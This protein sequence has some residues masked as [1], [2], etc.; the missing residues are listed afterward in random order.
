MRRRPLPARVWD[1]LLGNALGNAAAPRRPRL[2]L[3]ALEAREVPAVITQWDFNSPTPD[4]DVTTGTDTPAVGAGPNATIT[5]V[6]GLAH[7]FYAAESPV[8]G[9]SSDPATADDSSYYLTS[10]PAQGTAPNSAGVEWHVDT[11]GYKDVVVT[12]DQYHSLT[13]PKHTRFRYSTDGGATWAD[14]PLFTAA[15][16]GD[17]WYNGR[18][19]DL[20]GV[21]AAGN[22]PDLRVKVVAAYAPG[23]S[24]YAATKSGST[25][26]GGGVAN[27]AWRLDM[28]TV[29]GTALPVVSVE[30]VGD[31]T[32]GGA[33]GAFRFTRTGP[34]GGPLTAAYTVGGTAT[35]GADYA[36]LSGAVT[37]AAG[38]SA[39][40][41]PMAAVNDALIE[42]AETVVVAVSGAGVGGFY[43]PGGGAA[44]VYVFSDDIPEFRGGGACPAGSVVGSAPGAAAGVTPGMSSGNPVR[45]ADGVLTYAATDL[46]GGTAAGWGLQ[47]SWTNGTG[48]AT[49]PDAGNGWVLTQAPA[50]V[51][52]AVGSDDTV[53]AI[54]NGTTG[55]FFDLTGGGYAARGLDTAGL[56]HDTTAHRF[57]LTDGTGARTTFY[58]FDAS[59]PAGQRGRFAGYEDAA[60]TAVAVVA[61]DALGRPLEVEQAVTAGGVTTTDGYLYAYGTG[62]GAGD[63][64][65]VTLRRKVG[66]GGWAAVRSVEYAYHDGAT[67]GGTAGDLESATVKDENG[68]VVSTDYYRYY[69]DGEAGG[70]AGALKLVVSGAG[71]DRAAAEVAGGVA[72]AT[73]AQ[74]APYAAYAYEYD[75]ERRVTQEVVGGAGCSACSAGLGTVG[76][77]YTMSTNAAGAN[78][79][80]GRAVETGPNGAVTTVYTNAWGQVLLRAVAADGLAWAEYN[81]YDGDGRLVLAAAPSAVSGYDDAYADLVHFVSGDAEYL[82]DA[83]GLITAYTYGDSTTATGSAAGDAA[84]YLK[85]V[86]IRQGEFGAAVPQ[87]AVTYLMNTAGGTDFF[88]VAAQTVYRNDDGT[89]ARTTS[90]AY[91]FVSGTNQIASTTVTLPAVTAAQN[92]SG[93]ATATT[94][95]N[96]AFGRPVWMRDAGGFLTYVEYD[97][98]TGAAVKTIT[99]VDTTQ[100][101]TFANL[102]SGWATPSGGGL[103]LT[104]ATEVD[105]LGRA[106]K[107]TA[108]NGRVDYTVYDE[109]NHAVRYYPGWDAA[110]SAPTG[111]T[112]VSRV[113]RAGGY[114]ESLTMSAAP[115]V[116]GGRPTGAE[117]ISGL[118]SLSRSYTNAAGQVV[119]SDVYF[120]LAGLTYSTA[121]A[122]GVEGVNFY[123]TRYQYDDT[124]AVS[125]A[126]SAAGTVTRT[127]RDGLGRAASE[128]V[129]TDDTPTTGYWSPTNLAGTDMVKVAEYEYDGGGVGDGNLTTMTQFPGGGAADRVTRTWF[130]WRDRAVAVKSGVEATEAADVNRPLA[131]YDY[132]N[133]GAVTRTRVYDA[134]GVTPTVT[135]GVPQPPSA[136]LLRAQSATSY[137]EMGRAYRS[138]TY[139]VDPASGAVGSY[140]LHSETWYDARGQVVKSSAAGGLVQK[141]TY[142]GAGRAVARYVTDGGGDMGYA[143]AFGVTGDTV[144]S[145]SEVFYDAAGNV[146]ST[147]GRERF[148]DATG[149]GALGSPTSGVGAR[150]SYA[151]YYYDAGDRTV[152]TVDVGTNGGAAWTR[153]GGVPTGSATVRVSGMSYDAAGRVFETVDPAGRVGRTEY[154]A[155]GRTTKTVRN[156]VDGVVSDGDDKTVTYAYGP[157]GLTGLTAHLTGGGYQTTQYLF[158]VSQADGS[159]VASNDVMGQT[160]WP[161]P[162]LGSAS[163]SENEETT[164][165][166]LGQA[167]TQ[168][169]R[170]GTVHTLTYDVLGRVVADAVT[171][172]GAGVDGAVR[173]VEYAYDGQG[174]AY[175]VTSYDAATGGSVVSQVRRAFNGLGQM[176]AEWQEH[177]GAVNT[178][179]TPQVGY[180]YSEM[181]GGANH[182]RLTSVTYPDGYVL[183]YNY[184]SGLDDGIG[185][186]SS[187]SDAAG[188]VESYSY[189]GLGTVVVRSHPQAD[190]TLTYVGTPGDG[191]DQYAGLDRFGRV[192]DQRWVNT[193]TSA[194]LDR[195]TYTYDVSGNRLTRGNGVNGAFDEAYTYD[196]LDQLAGFARGTHTQAWDY[197]AVGNFEGVTTDGGTPQTRT[198]N[199]QNQ[200]TS[201]GGA[202]TPTYD[203]NGNMT[204][205]ET[206]RRL[207]YDA[208]NRLVAVKDSGGTVLKTYG[209]DGLGRR[210]QETVTAT[211]VT[212]DLYYSAQW[213]VLE[214]QVAGDTT[215][216]YVWSPVYVDAMVLRDRDT[217]ADGTLDER[218]WVQQDANWNV[219]ALVNGSGAVVERYAYDPFGVRTVYDASYSV[220]SG[221]SSYDFQHGFQGMAADE[222]SG[223]SHQRNRWYSPTLGR[224]V[225]LDPI[226]FAGGDV[227]LYRAMGNNTTNYI[228]P[229]GLAAGTVDSVNSGVLEYYQNVGWVDWEHASPDAAKLVVTRLREALKFD[230]S[231][232]KR[233]IKLPDDF[234]EGNGYVIVTINDP[235]DSKYP[236]KHYYVKKDLPE[237][238]FWSVAFAIHMDYQLSVEKLQG[239]AGS[240]SYFSA[241]D[242]PSNVIGFY[243]YM[244]DPDG[245]KL[246]TNAATA[247]FLGFG[248]TAS[249][250]ETLALLKGFRNDLGHPANRNFSFRPFANCNGLTGSLKDKP[251]SWPFDPL[252]PHKGLTPVIP[253]SSK[254]WWTSPFEMDD[255]TDLRKKNEA[256]IQKK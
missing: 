55:H 167:L 188:T 149:T 158:G 127:V 71:Y 45:Y 156:Y 238:E 25:Y 191:G 240:G 80:S 211:S 19:V 140:T 125:R 183:G 111:P 98:Y 157:A 60:G 109:A 182:S 189:L 108:P 48:Y 36:A 253:A 165:N 39:V 15:S 139:A 17:K 28:V 44:T 104:T 247:K 58:D 151:G 177:G 70:Y 231:K 30:R 87:S 65:G 138:D 208:W 184:A 229:S 169:D 228:D 160:R 150:V 202:T 33:A 224:W 21:A 5:T 82:R 148:H 35:P 241:E 222:V 113:D 43:A 117:G 217:N 225:T 86:T 152:A 93:S 198:A 250:E 205:D 209:Y 164:F 3:E 8:K 166:A 141:V 79:W 196:A 173:R 16:G 171:T 218:L 24:G 194:V 57:V 89:G 46:G 233:A 203:A 102:P 155:L 186:L 59:Y 1:Y 7:Q 195:F 172:L 236:G 92:G 90:Y 193:A 34:T 243:R 212:T 214:E 162:A 23:T 50:L 47:R 62:G 66:S 27:P 192:V 132:D 118:Q 254:W 112:V 210:V 232:A 54:T 124:G 234:F 213:Q 197:D 81:R 120:N 101:A 26:G 220:R 200:I 9:N 161:D 154:D 143:D 37:F 114:T 32:E 106:T 122:L 129:G 12:W 84:G 215:Q 144:L 72:A 242:L 97:T 38:Q 40:L 20:S 6:G 204:G 136:S 226:R 68:A 221:G 190:N 99:D 246:K 119:Y 187:L 237:K 75:A 88:H 94:T 206:G 227:N 153:P 249:K 52:P 256:D 176:T 61:S 163:S 175:L 181:T 142:D 77:A 130:D 239:R 51:R 133:L 96:D 4:G 170:N 11:T 22:N 147:I 251:M 135:G 31:A 244:N 179:T 29:G 180:A 83:A 85:A 69:A 41:V 56:T 2:A 168:D 128:W 74:L 105:A 107:T 110:T 137:D 235:G 174:N 78:S 146:I 13:S 76:Y 73:D 145:Q 14:G 42:P 18:T 10:F 255:L 116:A 252:T 49:R 223:L 199:A 159:L 67:A 95:V 53:V 219:T 121:A 201:I 103:H 248:D 178:A 230:G 131:Y 185:R 216:R 207:V 63:L 245:T 115:A 91:T 100:T 134:D 123:R 126:V 64:L